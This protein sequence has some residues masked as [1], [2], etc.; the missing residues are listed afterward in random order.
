MT[1]ESLLYKVL[2]QPREQLPADTSNYFYVL[3]NEGLLFLC[4]FYCP[5]IPIP[6]YCPA[7]PI[8]F[9]PLLLLFSLLLFCFALFHCSLMSRYRTKLSLPAETKRLPCLGKLTTVAD[10]LHTHTH[11]HT[12]THGHGHRHTG[13][14]TDT[15]TDAQART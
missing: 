3:S 13:T 10:P 7:I 15:D 4:H 12:H 5:A 9:Y 1:D 2:A 14:C 11:T 6:F 8:P